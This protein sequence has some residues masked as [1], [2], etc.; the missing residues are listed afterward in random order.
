MWKAIYAEPGEKPRELRGLSEIGPAAASEKGTLWVDLF[1]AD[2]TETRL[3]TDVFRLDPLAVEDCVTEVHHPKVDDYGDYLYLAVHGV[4]GGSR[5][6]GLGTIELDL[7][8]SRHWLITFR[9]DE[10]RS[11]AQTWERCL[12]QEGFL[13]QGPD[14]CL[15]HV[16]AAQADHFVD[17]VEKLHE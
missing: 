13:G 17:E 16:L 6:G 15:Q 12:R 7:V 1:N 5:R 2:E 8:L 11:V 4:K 14:A 3:L 10:M 9:H